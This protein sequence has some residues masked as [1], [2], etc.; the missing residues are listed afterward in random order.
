MFKSVRARTNLMRAK[1]VGNTERERR[2]KVLF[3]YGQGIKKQNK[4]KRKRPM[5]EQRVGDLLE[6]YM[7]KH[8]ALG[9]TARRDYILTMKTLMCF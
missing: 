4:Q 9:A 5:D 1:I 8:W 2:L 6:K 3:L 7:I